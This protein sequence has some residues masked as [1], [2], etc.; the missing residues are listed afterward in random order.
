MNYFNFISNWVI[1]LFIIWFI[2]YMI[3]KNN[4]YLKYFNLY[5]LNLFIFYGFIGYLLFHLM[6]LNNKFNFFYTILN[7]LIHYLPVYVYQKLN[8]HSNKYSL[9][10][11][12]LIFMI[13]LF[14]IHFILN[15]NMINIYF[16]N[17]Q[18][19]QL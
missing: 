17:K 4:I 6:I 5:Y 3:N 10:M 16:I 14:Y 19:F 12:I 9:K 8:I 1:L 7:I 2:F 18:L 11:F 13:Y 15:T